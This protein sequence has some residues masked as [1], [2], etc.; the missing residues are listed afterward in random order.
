MPFPGFRVTI[1][2]IAMSGGLRR[3]GPYEHEDPNI[4]DAIANALDASGLQQ[5]RHGHYQITI[6]DLR[7]DDSPPYRMDG[8]DHE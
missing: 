1:D 7:M 3:F 2:Q 5:A 8:C 4:D 6:T